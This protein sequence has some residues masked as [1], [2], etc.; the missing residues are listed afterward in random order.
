[1]DQEVEQLRL[2]I[3]R[4]TG[5][6]VE[7]D[8]PFL[9]ATRLLLASA[10][11]IEEKSGEA[12]EKLLLAAA[13]VEQS[14]EKRARSW[15]TP[16]PAVATPP[17]PQVP[18]FDLVAERNKAWRLAT[19]A[20]TASA[21]IFGT[22]GYVFRMGIDAASVAGFKKSAE[23]AIGEALVRAEA[24]EKRSTEEIKAV[25]AASG[26]VGTEDGKLAKRF[27]DAGGGPVAARCANTEAW[28][29]RESKGKKWC[30]PKPSSLFGKV[31]EGGWRIP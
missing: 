14:V 18:T 11:S 5:M 19:V 15:A 29:I 20:L 22:V 13:R 6:T 8:D 30:V 28:E 26:W 17:A 27:F 31:D 23:T 21:L 9:V 25:Q 2:E 12:A 4:R 10:K 16:V 24:A 3:F 7:P 1:M